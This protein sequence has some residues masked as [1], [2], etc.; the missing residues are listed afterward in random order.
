MH[1]WLIVNGPFFS[2]YKRLSVLSA[3]FRRQ[4][5][6]LVTLVRRPCQRLVCR[7]LPLPFQSQETKSPVKVKGNQELATAVRSKKT[8][9][10]VKGKENQ[11]LATVGGRVCVVAKVARSQA[12]RRPAGQRLPNTILGVVNLRGTPLASRCP[13]RAAAG[14]R[15]EGVCLASRAVFVGLHA[16]P[17]RCAP[18]RLNRTARRTTAR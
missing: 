6:F 11:D 2:D 9:T 8:E 18:A 17:L 12:Q 5:I 7:D 13:T 10:A 3:R 4:P 15:R 14:R 16:L 1:G